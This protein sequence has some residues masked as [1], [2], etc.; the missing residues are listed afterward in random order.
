MAQLQAS[1]ITVAHQE[2]P[3][4]LDRLAM[5]GDQVF[6][7][8]HMYMSLFS[9]CGWILRLTVTVILLISIHPMLGLLAAFALPTVLASTWRPGVGRAAE[10]RG[11]NYHSIRVINCV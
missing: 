5:L 11:R 9:T 8:D 2:R 7:L 3:D 4:C 6:V 1:V 10:E